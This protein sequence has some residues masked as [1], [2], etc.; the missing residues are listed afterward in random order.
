METLACFYLA[1]A[2]ESG[3]DDPALDV[4]PTPSEAMKSDRAVRLGQ[5]GRWCAS[6]L[7]LTAIVGLLGTPESA[8]AALTH[9]DRSSQVKDAQVRLQQL[10][11]FKASPTGYY[12]Q[13]TKASVL[14]FQRARGLTPDGVVGPQ[15]QAALLGSQTQVSQDSQPAVTYLG[16]GSQGPPVRSLQQRLRALGYYQGQITGNFDAATK[17]AVIRFQ[18]ASGLRSDGVVGPRTF[19]ALGQA[20]PRATAR[21]SPPTSTSTRQPTPQ[22]TYLGDG[23]QGPA[24]R[25]LQQ[26]LRALGYYQGEITGN[27]DSATQDAVMNFQLEQGLKPDG[28][29]GPRTFATLGSA[30]PIQRAPQ[31]QP[32][33]AN[34]TARVPANLNE[35]PPERVKELQHRLQELGFYQGQVDGVWGA[36]T[37]TALENA[38][39][40]Y[41]VSRDDIIRGQ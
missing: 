9:G 20:S 14:R 4:A 27:F 25:S 5:F 19:T 10:G 37:Q 31:P 6:L 8:K 16:E 32:A 11:Y 26:R 17:D 18:Q 33:P 2:H 36:G 12:G 29:V 24:V 39:R 28:V 23:S 7:G 34:T 22:V 13:I 40:F 38:Q 15:T 1:I 30:T 35:L 21:S 3:V 41:G